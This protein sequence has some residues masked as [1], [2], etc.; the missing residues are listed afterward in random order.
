MKKI[1][2][3]AMAVVLFASCGGNAAEKLIAVYE[4]ATEEIQSAKCEEEFCMIDAKLEYELAKI[5]YENRDE[6]KAMEKKMDAGDAEMVKFEEKFAEARKAYRNAAKEARKALP[7]AY[8]EFIVQALND[9]SGVRR[10]RMHP[11]AITKRMLPLGL[12]PGL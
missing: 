4:D 8:A 9:C 11:R 10:M 2:M 3:F 5:R 1:L 12:E 6:L 7:I